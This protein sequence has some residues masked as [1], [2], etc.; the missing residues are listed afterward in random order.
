[1]LGTHWGTV[2][3]PRRSSCPSTCGIYKPDSCPFPGGKEM[4]KGPEQQPTGGLGNLVPGR[5]S[6]DHRHGLWAQP[7]LSRER[8][9]RSFQAMTMSL[10]ATRNYRSQDIFSQSLLGQRRKAYKGHLHTHT[11]THT[12]TLS[13]AHTHLCTRL[14]KPQ[15]APAGTLTD[16]SRS[17]SLYS[18]RD[19][20]S[21]SFSRITTDPHPL[22]RPP[23]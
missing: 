16:L 6:R 10:W 9:D 23:F 21:L 15:P 7:T 22:P 12:H 1:M 8:N 11:L 3:H 20:R 17:Q 19:P 5:G 13:L 18:S 14:P 2:G 4:G